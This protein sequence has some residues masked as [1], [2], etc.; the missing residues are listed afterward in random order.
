MKDYVTILLII[1]HQIRKKVLQLL[2]RKG[3][4]LSNNHERTMKISFHRG[5]FL[6]WPPL[7]DGLEG[8]RSDQIQQS[9]TLLRFSTK[10]FY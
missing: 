8:I 4:I 6:I 10:S 3:V 9:E 2:F 1:V 7:T 5:V